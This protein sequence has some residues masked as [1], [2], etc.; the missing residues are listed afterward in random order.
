MSDI[1]A[2]LRTLI[3]AD[4]QLVFVDRCSSLA[5]FSLNVHSLLQSV[6]ELKNAD[7]DFAA[8][9]ATQTFAMRLLSCVESGQA[10]K[11]RNTYIQRVP[12]TRVHMCNSARMVGISLRTLYLA[13]FFMENATK[14]KAWAVIK[15]AYLQN[16]F[17]DHDAVSG[18]VVPACRIKKSKT[19]VAVANGAAT[20]GAIVAP[21]PRLLQLIAEHQQQLSIEGVA[22]AFKKQESDE[23]GDALPEPNDSGAGASATAKISVGKMYAFMHGSNT[24]SHRVDP[25]VHSA[26]VVPEHPLFFFMMQGSEA[27]PLLRNIEA[28][29]TDASYEDASEHIQS[30]DGDLWICGPEGSRALVRLATKVADTSKPDSVA[31][32]ALASGSNAIPLAVQVDGEQLSRYV[33]TFVNKCAALSSYCDDKVY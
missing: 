33:A 25:L 17:A 26:F 5:L 30:E 28:A 18:D 24:L 15:A 2:S 19:P 14:F 3:A 21:H 20:T 8:T 1:Q 11:M 4:S 22:A 12:V 32:S 10:W 6:Q 31:Y 7:K 27:Q 23:R 9:V 16:V 29:R 13:A